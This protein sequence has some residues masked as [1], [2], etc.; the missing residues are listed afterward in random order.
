MAGRAYDAVL[1]TPK[2]RL[3]SQTLIKKSSGTINKR[4]GHRRGLSTISHVSARPTIT[5]N[6]RR[7][8]TRLIKIELREFNIPNASSSSALFSNVNRDIQV[9][10]PGLCVPIG[11]TLNLLKSLLGSG[12]SALSYALASLS[13]S[14]STVKPSFLQNSLTNS[15]V[16]AAVTGEVCKR[17]IEP[18]SRLASDEGCVA[19]AMHFSGR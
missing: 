4:I 3:P 2:A 17:I 16:A 18:D 12:P 5:S 9:G 15:T 11:G 8:R 1:R 6:A 14:T 10:G 13:R 7:S 19:M